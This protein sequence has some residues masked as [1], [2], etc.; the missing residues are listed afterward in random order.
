MSKSDQALD[1][2]EQIEKKI[3]KL[4]KLGFEFMYFNSISS[5]RRKRSK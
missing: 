1:L 4:S 2:Q 5:I 3:D